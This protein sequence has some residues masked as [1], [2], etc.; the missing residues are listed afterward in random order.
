MLVVLF[1]FAF[2]FGLSESLECSQQWECDKK[3]GSSV[4]VDY[5]F[6]QCVNG[7]CVCAPRGFA[8]NASV[9]NKCRCESPRSVYWGGSPNVAYC[10]SLNEA[11]AAQQE[12]IKEDQQLSYVNQVFQSLKWPT[13]ALIIQALI[14]GGTHP[15]FKLFAADSI[16]RVNPLGI[17]SGID[18]QLE[19][20]YGAV[21]TGITQIDSV[22]YDYLF[23][24]GDYVYVS[25][26]LHFLRFNESNRTQLQTQYNLTLKGSFTFSIDPVDGVNKIHSEDLDIPNLGAAVNYSTGGRGLGFGDPVYAQSTCQKILA[27]RSVGG[28]GC[29]AT[30]DPLGYYHNMSDCVNHFVNVYRPGTMDNIWFDGDT[31][32]CRYYHLI[33]AFIFPQMHCPHI[34]KTGADKCIHHEYPTY[35]DIKY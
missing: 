31:T 15:S 7:Q 5:N 16:G 6:V 29:D 11:V 2:L 12:H 20:F 23:S 3:D 21:W 4:T 13:P 30:M 27:P 32:A 24:Q 33:L 22:K 9:G 34:G 19:Y 25:A 8:G 18:G 10:I 26:V 28:A 35:Y 17:F 1:I 14:T